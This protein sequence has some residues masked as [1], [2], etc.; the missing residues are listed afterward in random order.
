MDFSIDGQI[1]SFCSD[2]TESMLLIVIKNSLNI[3]NWK[4]GKI[5]FRWIGGK[6]GNGQQST[7][8]SAIMIK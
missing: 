6:T 7:D 3:S 4:I 1:S 5:Q 8:K 2:H